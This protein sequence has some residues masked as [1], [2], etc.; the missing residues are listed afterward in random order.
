MKMDED[1]YERQKEGTSFGQRPMLEIQE[2]TFS[3]WPYH[4]GETCLNISVGGQ[5]Y[6]S[7]LV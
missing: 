3:A 2:V 5:L 6:W 1:A 7:P 4:H